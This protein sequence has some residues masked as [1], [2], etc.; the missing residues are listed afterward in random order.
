MLHHVILSQKK[1]QFLKLKH[2]N[3]EADVSTDIFRPLERYPS[4]PINPEA[5]ELTH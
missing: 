3:T 5:F 4:I 1:I 2:I